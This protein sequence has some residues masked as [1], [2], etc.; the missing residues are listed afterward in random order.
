[1][2]DARMVSRRSKQLVVIAVALVV[3]FAGRSRGSEPLP[4]TP[5]PGSGVACF[6]QGGDRDYCGCL[7]RLEAARAVTG[8]P[9]SQLPPLNH[10]VIQYAMRHPRQYP[11]IN[12]DTLRCL[13]P[14]APRTPAVFASSKRTLV[15]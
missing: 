4:L 14:A 15:V 11:I 8:R 12:S 3:G 9:A 10:S 13:T 5:P 7:D 2:P 6:R 1:M